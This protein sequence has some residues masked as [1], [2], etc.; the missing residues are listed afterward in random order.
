MG[1]DD[2]QNYLQDVLARLQGIED[3]VGAPA[4]PAVPAAQ[5]TVT[6]PPADPMPLVVAIA[7]GAVAVVVAL[8]ALLLIRQT[9]ALV[10]ALHPDSPSDPRV[11][12]RQA[13][14]GLLRRYSALLGVELVTG[15]VPDRGDTSEVLR[16]QLESA[17]GAVPDVGAIEL[18]DEVGDARIALAGEPDRRAAHNGIVAMGVE[19]SIDRWVADPQ[20]WL[21]DWREQARLIRLAESLQVAS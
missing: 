6:A 20:T 14:A 1:P 17:V 10:R 15:R 9:Q 2:F 3:A 11:E 18:L 19:W 4:A 8:I 13:F 12:Q 5:V 21:A 16:S 7:L